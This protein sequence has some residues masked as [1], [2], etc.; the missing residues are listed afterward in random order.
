LS[1]NRIE[2]LPSI[3]Q[4]VLSE[5]ELSDKNKAKLDKL[6]SGKKPPTFNQLE[7]FSKIIYI[8]LGY[9]FLKPPPNKEYKLLEFR[10][11]DS[12]TAQKPNRNLLDTVSQME[13]VQEWM[14][15]HILLAA[16]RKKF[17][18]PVR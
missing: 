8:P 17:I 7:E 9:F 3:W 16:V 2:V 12:V 15:E 18:S 11:I 5:V 6:V 10:T 14:R 4:W 1:E 13:N